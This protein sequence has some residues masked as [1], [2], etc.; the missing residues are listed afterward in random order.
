MVKLRYTSFAIDERSAEMP[1]AEG[2]ILS[3]LLS[4][5][6]VNVTGEHRQIEKYFHIMLNG[7]KT[8]AADW[9]CVVLKS[10]DEVLIAPILRGGDNNSLLRT[11]F[12]I[13][14]VVTTG[15][16]AAGLTSNAYILAGVQTATS[17]AA[18]YI[19]F[20]A[21]PSAMPEV[22]AETYSTADS[23][24]YSISSQSNEVRKFGLVP[25]VYGTHRVF[26]LVAA[27][28]YTDLQ[29]L[30]GELVQYLYAIY[31][32]GLGP[33]VVSDI[34]IGDS[35]ITNFSDYEINLVDPNRPIDSEGVWDE[36][37]SQEFLLYKGDVENESLSIVLNENEIDAGPESGYRVTR[38]TAPNPDGLDQEIS[39]NFLNPQ[40]LISYA[41]NGNTGDRFIDLKVEFRKAGSSDP[42]RDYNAIGSSVKNF[43]Y[44]GGEEAYA[45][46][47]LTLLPPALD[48]SYSPYDLLGLA[49]PQRLVS[50]TETPTLRTEIYKTAFWAG[51]ARFQTPVLRILDTGTVRNTII[52]K[53]ITYSGPGGQ[54]ILGRVT[55]TSNG[56]SGYFLATLDTPLGETIFTHTVEYVQTVNTVI[57]S[58]LQGVITSYEVGESFNY[59]KMKVIAGGIFRI[60]ARTSSP[61]YSSLRFTPY[62]NDQMEVKIT[63]VSS[64]GDFTSQVRDALVLS[65]IGAKY[66]NRFTIA[67]PK[68][69]SF[70]ELKIRATNQ[71][72]GAIQNL[73]CVVQS[74][75]DVWDG[76]AWVKQITSNPAWV[77][78]DILSGEI[79]KRPIDKSRL[80]TP[81]LLEWANYCDQVPSPPPGFTNLT[82][83]FESNFVFDFE[84][85]AKQL[86]E[87]VASLGQAGLSIIDGKYG[88][89]IDKRRTNPIQLFTP[90]NSKNFNS[91]KSFNR[92]V[93]ALKI[94]YIDPEANWELREAIVYEE[95]YS[96]SNATEF[97]EV[98]TFGITAPQQAWRLGRFMIAVNRLRQETMSLD[99]DFEYLVCSRGDYVKIS[100]DVMKVGGSPARVKSI[101]GNRIV[102]DDSIET[103]VA[104]YGY[105][106]RART[107][108]ILTNTLTVVNADTFDL[109]GTPLPQVGDLIIIGVVSQVTYDCIVKSISPKDDLTATLVLVERAD[110][111][112]DAESTGTF[113]TYDPQISIASNAQIDPPGLVQDLVVAD[114]FYECFGDGYRHKVSLDWD[115]PT[116]GSA[117]EIFEIYANYGRGFDVVGTTRNS[118]F[119]Y[120]VDNNNLGLTHSF[121]VLG[122]SATGNKL[123]LGGLASVTS[124]PLAKTTRPS[125]VETFNSD[126]TGEV[127][128]LFWNKI[129]DCDCREYLIRYSPTLTGT[130]VGSIPLMKVSKETSTTATQARTGTY[131]IKAVDIA[132]NE[133]ADATVI[134]TTIPEL[135]GL[136]VI[137]EVTDFPALNGGK[138]RTETF[139][140][141][142][143]VLDTAIVGG[144]DTLEYYSEGYYYYEELL[145]LG[146][147][148]TVRLQSSIQAEGTTL[149]DLMIN[150]ITLD[151]ISSLT[152]VASSDWDVEAQYRGTDALNVMESWATLSSIAALNQGSE[153]SFTPWRKFVMGDATFRIAQFRL[154]LISNKPSV[155]PRVFDGTIKA[156]MPDRDEAYNELTAPD[157]GYTVTYSPAFKGPGTTPSVNISLQNGQAGDRW[158][159][160]SKSLTGFT[161]RF[162]DLS[163][164]PVSRIFDARVKGYGRKAANTL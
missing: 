114:T 101:T 112:Y 149:S 124:T 137:S 25:K 17:I 51:Y 3:D 13:A 66:L 42:W 34:R 6:F 72:N 36:T 133:S 78:A 56:P 120:I 43:E 58:G 161:I 53:V 69:H 136:N 93:H 77:F 128:Q 151:S 148:Y 130:W 132:G 109:N 155:T 94:Q 127:L 162:Y 144:V 24:M 110:E 108:E 152:A 27:A 117:Y 71:L 96:E 104:S 153:D 54:K 1:I 126:I 82:K 70:L 111:I 118:F 37:H 29:T 47:P 106:F 33:N 150:W 129:P 119:E 131:L 86:M 88:V 113:P 89:L 85:T 146:D 142:S 75:L 14:A 147:I 9:P 102:I 92:R 90:R 22:K 121:K 134:I 154:K 28:P 80:H 23:Q 99:V 64:A 160:V 65:N 67:T 158:Q 91:S 79:N 8:L 61:Y 26:P 74:V 98:P 103:I 68:R 163:G 105:T 5:L 48:G 50:V 2:T 11:A 62:N 116:S 45:D 41:S 46:I 52:G 32:I 35:P 30:N 95:G 138:D 76:T 12:I 40:G 38:N 19:A 141:G 97:E 143:L 15:G 87:R 59:L 4:N 122:V 63:R 49:I 164:T 83:R 10:S 81:S 73:S 39:L 139:T 115:V 125:N 100:Q 84:S 21:F 140:G 60:R 18:T 55:T 44:S 156:D 31:D 57:S 7:E 107:G 157:T 20:T 145:D 123:D 16:I 159:F 135:T